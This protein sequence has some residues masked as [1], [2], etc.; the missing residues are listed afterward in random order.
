MS[1]CVNDRVLVD[2]DKHFE[3]NN[4]VT[5]GSVRFSSCK[6]LDNS[7]ISYG[8]NKALSDGF[9]ML[10]VS[11]DDVEGYSPIIFVENYCDNIS[12]KDPVYVIGILKN[13]KMHELFTDKIIP[14]VDD[15]DI[16]KF[17]APHSFVRYGNNVW[18]GF[19]VLDGKEFDPR[20]YYSKFCYVSCKEIDRI[21]VLKYI[22]YF[23]MSSKG[24]YSDYI[25]KLKYI[26]NKIEDD[27]Y[28]ILEAY[29]NE[30][31]VAKDNYVKRKILK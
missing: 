3:F 7:F 5:F 16:I 12:W 29:N 25:N 23:M 28:K 9:Y 1:S 17:C 4:D 6:C 13:G 22:E 19:P 2:L 30:L 31:D 20:I 18:E 14:F 15:V 26:N 8:K 11:S 10:G 24:F 21:D 27:Y